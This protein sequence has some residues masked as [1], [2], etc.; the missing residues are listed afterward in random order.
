MSKA[1]LVDA[2]AVAALFN[3]IDRIADATGAPLET[4]KAEAT[5]DLRAE[6][7]INSFG[8]IKQALDAEGAKSAAE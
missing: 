4:V 5:E 6:I 7:G 8:E 1:A 3:G 2:V